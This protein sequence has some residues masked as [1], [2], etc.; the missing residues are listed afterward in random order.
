MKSPRE[1]LSLDFGWKFALGHACDPACDFGFGKTGMGTY[2]KSGFAG[3]PTGIRFHDS[4]WESVQ[5]Q[6]DWAVA[7]PFVVEEAWLGHVQSPGPCGSGRCGSGLNLEVPNRAAER[8]ELQWAAHGAQYST[9]CWQIEYGCRQMRRTR[10][11]SYGLKEP[12][13]FKLNRTHQ[14]PG[15]NI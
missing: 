2:A 11:R 1:R 9:K 3:G 14:I 13:R 10:R 8:D 15:L 5:T 6:H 7:L 4:M 12:Q